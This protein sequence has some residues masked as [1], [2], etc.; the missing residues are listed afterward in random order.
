[1]LFQKFCDGVLYANLRSDILKR[2]HFFIFFHAQNSILNGK[3]TQKLVFLWKT[4][5]KFYLTTALQDILYL[6]KIFFIYCSNA[7]I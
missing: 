3:R 7:S 6:I 5:E 2:N 4:C 1:M